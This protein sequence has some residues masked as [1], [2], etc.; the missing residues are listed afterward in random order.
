M[1]LHWWTGVKLRQETNSNLIYDLACIKSVKQKKY[2]RQSEILEWFV[3][4]RCKI[5]T[6]HETRTQRSR[7]IFPRFLGEVYVVVKFILKFK[8]ITQTHSNYKIQK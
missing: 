7:V 4:N 1:G 2:S 5:S 6:T 3:T 8:K